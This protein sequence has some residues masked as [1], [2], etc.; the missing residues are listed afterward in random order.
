MAMEEIRSIVI[1]YPEREFEIRRRCTY[2]AHFRSVCA[3]YEEASAALRNWQKAVE[4]CNRRVEEYAS[5]LAELETEILD[6][7]DQAMES[8]RRS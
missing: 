7:L 6:R 2:D 3:D 8:S 1:R 4:G 5:F